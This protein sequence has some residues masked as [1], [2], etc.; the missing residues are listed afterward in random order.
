MW[1]IWD[2]RGGLAPEEAEELEAALPLGA[3]A[4]IVSGIVLRP[5][6][7]NEFADVQQT[8]NILLATL[9]TDGA[10]LWQGLE[11]LTHFLTTRLTKERRP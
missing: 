4:H 2:V 6:S 8:P 1:P 11:A 9:G 10:P 3:K 7:S 5:S